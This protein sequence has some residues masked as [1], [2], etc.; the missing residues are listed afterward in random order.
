MV[1]LLSP[2]KDTPPP[3]QKQRSAIEVNISAC[4]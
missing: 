2:Q 1:H 3:K 4:D